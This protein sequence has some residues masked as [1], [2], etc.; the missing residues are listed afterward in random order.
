MIIKGGTV[1]N[2]E[3][4]FIKTDIRIKDGII[5][6]IGTES[7]CDIDATDLF[8]V[9]GFI[10]THFHGAV[11]EEFLDFNENT[12]EK[13]ALYTAKC[14]TTS[15]VPTISAAKKEK[16][17]NTIEYLNKYKD[18]EPEGASKFLGVHLEGPFMSFKYKGAH[19]E[20]NLRNPNIEEFSEYVEKAEG[21]L[22]IMTLA[23]ELDGATDVIDMAREKG[24][25]ISVGHTDAN[26]DVVLDAIKHGAQQFTHLFNAMKGIN[27]REP[28]TVS[29]ALFSES[30]VEIICD[31]FHVHPDIIKMVYNLKGAG[32]IN[33][34]TDSIVAKGLEDGEYVANGSKLIIKGGHAYT[35]DGT[36]AGST[37]SM[38]DAVKNAVSIGISLEKAVM[39]ATKN[40]AESVG[41]YE[42]IGSI[43]EGKVA[44]TLI[45]DKN[46]DI[47]HIILRGNL[48]V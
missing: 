3:F 14:G 31:L 41:E 37:I 34:I 10:D 1:L 2:H 25:T 22:K 6:K 48:L 26:Y 12:Y 23:P 8:V 20:E 45:L 43:K 35:E 32:K 33:L 9:P 36:I 30:K 46:L 7:G 28:G 4:E 17:L 21:N 40:P 24:I 18:N 29:A 16:I 5:E 38:L 11:G 44:D 19:L 15:I 27:H 42:K 13:I 47:K 39:M